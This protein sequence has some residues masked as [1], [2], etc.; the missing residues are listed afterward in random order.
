MGPAM[1][2]YARLPDGSW[3]VLS[4][5]EVRVGQSVNVERRDGSVN[6]HRIQRVVGHTD[7]GW[8][9]EIKCQRGR[10]YQDGTSGEGLREFMQSRRREREASSEA[11]G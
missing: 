11:H 6:P 3:G 10:R 9:S 1:H 2:T 4:R 8:I 7:R 5:C